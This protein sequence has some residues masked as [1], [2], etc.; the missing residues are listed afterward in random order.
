MRGLLEIDV[1]NW[2]DVMLWAT[3]MG[4]FELAR[5]L[6]LK[7]SEPLRAAVTAS[8]I[9]SRLKD[10]MGSNAAWSSPAMM[11][12]LQRGADD[13]ESWAVDL[14]DQF[15]NAD[16]AVLSLT[17]VPARRRPS[18]AKYDHERTSQSNDLRSDVRKWYRL[19]PYSIIF[20]AASTSHPCR[21]VIA[22]PYC[23]HVVLSHF[24][25]IYRG[26]RACVPKSTT[27]FQL[28]SQVIVH[29][30][31]VVPVFWLLPTRLLMRLLNISCHTF[32]P[33]FTPVHLAASAHSRDP[34]CE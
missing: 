26:S 7:T 12:E 8:Q 27:F 3:L 5:L 33:V 19:W 1:V 21:R 30:V 23:Q 34:I 14:L 25:G 2:T 20:G 24:L 16:D 11:G 4:H 18:S 9:V 28:L 17:G 22:H 13:I 15:R 10:Q 32:M 29:M 31:L 6:W